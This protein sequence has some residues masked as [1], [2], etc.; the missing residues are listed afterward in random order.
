V[1]FAVDPI[2]SGLNK[3]PRQGTK[4]FFA[5]RL[6]SVRKMHAVLSAFVKKGRGA[7]TER[8]PLA[9][10]ERLLASLF[11]TVQVLQDRFDNK[12]IH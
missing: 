10:S 9:S 1:H 12:V 2:R 5:E 6:R 11:L 7:E 4:R 8:P 3:P